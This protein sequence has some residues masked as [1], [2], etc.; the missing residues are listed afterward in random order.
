MREC[1]N[2]GMEIDI[3]NDP[4]VDYH[5]IGN[6]SYALCW[7]CYEQGLVELS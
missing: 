3:E 4:W 1:E 7:E 5:P 2:C 6:E